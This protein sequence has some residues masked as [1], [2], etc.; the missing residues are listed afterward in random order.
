MF[1]RFA[2]RSLR[3]RAAVLSSALICLALTV[4]GCDTGRSSAIALSGEPWRP[5]DGLDALRAPSCAGATGDEAGEAI[6]LNASRVDLRAL[7]DGVHLFNG[8]TRVG[9][10]HLTSPD[11][12]FGGLSGL[13]ALPSGDLLA[14]SDQGAFVWIN[15]TGTSPTGARL[16]PMLGADGAPIAGKENQDAEGVTL[17]DGVA[18][19]SF[20]RNHRIEAFDLARCGAAAR[21]VPAI[22]IPNRPPQLGGAMESNGGVEGLAYSP[23]LRMVWVGIETSRGLGQPLG[24]IDSAGVPVVVDRLEAAPELELT[25]LDAS[26]FYPTALFRSYEPGVGNTILVAFVDGG[27]PQANSLVNLVRLEP[28]VPVDNFE[29]I[30]VQNRGTRGRRLWIVSDDNFSSS[31]RTL[32]MAFDLP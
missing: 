4:A 5:L 32:L 10:W 24:Q 9:A 23:G 8:A 17:V 6:A 27:A 7:Q 29:G 11:P 1:R 15:L 22:T 31:Q 18:L 28:S 13:A 19:V 16:A 14:V 21:A 3:G 20:E 30:A 12:R 2:Q 26:Q 25:G